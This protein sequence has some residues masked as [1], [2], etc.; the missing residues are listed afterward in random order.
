MAT[1]KPFTRK[2][3][4]GAAG[5][6]SSNGMAALLP[7][8][9]P[10]SLGPSILRHAEAS[11]WPHVVPMTALPGIGH[12]LTNYSIGYVRLHVVG[13][14][15]LLLPVP[16]AVVAWIAVDES[17]VAAQIAGMTITAG[18]LFSLVREEQARLHQ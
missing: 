6:P 10:L 9:L 11:D 1:V 15:N 5:S 7:A 3:R 12:V 18:A 2:R 4:V 8:T 17:L 14:V 16:A 13:N